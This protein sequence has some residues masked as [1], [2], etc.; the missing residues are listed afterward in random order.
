MAP[1]E[2]AFQRLKQL[3]N[4]YPCLAFYDVSKP[5]LLRIDASGYGLGAVLLQQQSA[6]WQPVA[7]ASRSVS[8]AERNYA[9]IEKECLAIVWGCEYFAQ[10]LVGSKPFT[11]HTDHKPLGPLVNS[12]DLDRVPLRCQR[13]LLR[14][15]RFDVTAEHVPC[16]D[17]IVAD[18][19][20]LE[21]HYT[22]YHHL[23][24]VCSD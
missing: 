4:Q 6:G 8:D 10:Y 17:L 2:E 15:A 12:R 11:V 5:T 20:S 14:L 22:T 18:A 24:L 23:Y 13:L 21:H 19:L 16:R 7:Y 3:A 9:Q 1:Q